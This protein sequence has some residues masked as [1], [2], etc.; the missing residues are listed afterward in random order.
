[1]IT[2]YRFPLFASAVLAGSALLTI[3]AAPQ[4][5]GPAPAQ[6]SAAT[7]TASP[8]GS[9]A[10]GAAAF[11][12]KP[13]EGRGATSTL[14]IP[15]TPAKAPDAQGFISRWLLLEPIPVS[16]D[17]TENASKAAVK[18]EYF[19]NQ[20]TVLPH[21]GDKVTVGSQETTWHA[22]DTIKLYNVNLYLFAN[23][24]EQIP[25]RARCSGPSRWSTARRTCPT[26]AWPSAPMRRRSGGST[27]RKLRGRL[28]RPPGGR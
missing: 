22:V 19:P 4:S 21:D 7:A 26:C 13:A 10:G 18:V 25:R 27:A 20:L 12:A 1:M 15:A 24:S 9:K 8:A 17:L 28:R 2:L 14:T 5:Q 3:A 6:K 11:P 23:R 16:S